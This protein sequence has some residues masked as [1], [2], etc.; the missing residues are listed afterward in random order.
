MIIKGFPAAYVGLY[1]RLKQTAIDN[2]YALALHGSLMRDMDLIA[3]P[4]TDEAS[5]PEVLI[6]AMVEC[7]GLAYNCT[8]VLEPE[9]CMSDGVKPHGRRAW[10]IMLGAGAYIDVSVMPKVS[11]SE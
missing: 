7:L 2:G 6:S 3:V 1:D 5:D 8:N 10:N 4:W 9:C 11:C